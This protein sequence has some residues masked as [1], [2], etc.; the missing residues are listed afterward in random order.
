MTVEKFFIYKYT[1]KINNKIYIGKTNNVKRR[2]TEHL[3][4]SGTMENNHF[5]NAIKKYGFENF[6]FEI[7]DECDDEN[8]SFELEI[9]YIAI[10]NS[11]DKTIGYNSTEGGEGVRNV[12]EALRKQISDRGKLRIGDKNTFYGKH[13]TDATKESIS[14]A[15][16]GKSPRLGKILS[17]ASKALISK[18]N[19]GKIRSL[20]QKEKL[21]KLNSGENATNAKITN[22]EAIQIRKENSL[23]I[24]RLEL[25]QK[26]NVSKSSIDRI[27]QFKTYLN[28][29]K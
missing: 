12:S 20:E 29:G 18:G 26:Y 1:N 21:S 17:Q 13:H 10:L 16:K 6:T 11:N 15:N 23:G 22:E 5:Y 2:Q 25:A 19:T 14:K 9:Y 28:A 24:S 8:K 7:I 27:I 3:S 4:R